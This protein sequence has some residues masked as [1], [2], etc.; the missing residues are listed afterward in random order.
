MQN[1]P[2]PEEID[3]ATFFAQF[4]YRQVHADYQFVVMERSP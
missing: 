3:D 4:G 1:W 2:D